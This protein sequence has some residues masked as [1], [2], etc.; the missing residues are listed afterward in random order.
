MTG[1][2]V[3]TAKRI[4]GVGVAD[5]AKPWNLG[6]RHHRC[7]NRV[8]AFMNMDNERQRSLEAG[9]ERLRKRAKKLAQDDPRA[10]V[11]V[12]ILLGILDLLG[13]EL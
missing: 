9:I 6:A 13:D 12:G 2:T 7:G 3:R 10:I 11:L 4:R 5:R 1:E 8:G